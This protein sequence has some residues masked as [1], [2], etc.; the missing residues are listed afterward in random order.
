MTYALLLLTAL[1]LELTL[2]L[3]V[4]SLPLALEHDGATREQIAMS[5]GAGMFTFLIVSIPIG[6]LV[7]RIGRIATMRL[8]VALAFITMIALYFTHG[9]LWFHDRPICL[10]KHDRT[11]RQVCVGSCDDGDNRQLLL[12]SSTGARGLS[13]AEWLRT[14]AILVG[15]VVNSNRRCFAFETAR[16]TRYENFC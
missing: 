2:N 9:S 11:E 5:M 12:R 4:G 8:G 1:C 14:R 3:P 13:L 7:D 15:R 10:W 6:A 16:Q